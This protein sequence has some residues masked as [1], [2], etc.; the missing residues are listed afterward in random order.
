MTQLK[1]LS[2]VRKELTLLYR[3]FAGLLVLFVMPVVLVVVVTLVQEN[4][5]KSMGETKTSVLFVDMDGKSV[6]RLIEE[7]MQK[8]GLVKVVKELKERRWILRPRKRPLRR[9]TSS[10]ASLFPK[11]LPKPSRKRREEE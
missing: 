2:S 7:A 1:L 9:E 6:G 11:G 3:D 5:L 8:S 10:S 4:V